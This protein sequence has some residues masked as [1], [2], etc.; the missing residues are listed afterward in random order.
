M[1]LEYKGR[2]LNLLPYFNKAQKLNGQFILI[3]FHRVLRQG[4]VKVDALARLIA[5]MALSENDKMEVIV[6]ERE[7]LPP[8]DTH[9][10]IIDASKLQK[11][12]IFL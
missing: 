12:K 11:A 8:L 3:E 9:Q 6:V 5:S 7:L 2:K 4:N 1:N 10:A